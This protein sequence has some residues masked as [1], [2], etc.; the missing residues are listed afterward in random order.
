MGAFDL[1]PIYLTYD[2][3]IQTK[4][5]TAIYRL[6]R[7]HELIVAAKVNGGKV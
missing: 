7:V 6:L 4:P 3:N 2:R 5:V 1:T